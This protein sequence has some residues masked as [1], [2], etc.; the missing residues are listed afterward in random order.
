MTIKEVADKFE[1]TNDTLRYYE[2]VGLIGPIKKTS[3]GIRNYDETDLRRIEFVKC[4]RSANLPIEAL[5]RYMQLFD[6]GD[7]TIK[8]RKTLLEEQREILKKQLDEMNKAY[9]RLNYKI[10]L[11]EHDML[12]KD[13]K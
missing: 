11:Y 13:L 7:S 1:L 9:D 12:E 4:M 3:T 6:Q 2:K 8:E 5:V 10:D